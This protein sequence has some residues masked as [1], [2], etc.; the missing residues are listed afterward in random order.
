MYVIRVL[1]LPCVCYKGPF[2]TLHICEK[3]SFLALHMIRVLSL[4]CTCDIRA[5]FLSCTSYMI[6]YNWPEARLITYLCLVAVFLLDDD[7]VPVTV[8]DTQVNK[9]LLP[10]LYTSFLFLYFNIIFWF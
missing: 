5:L 2:P 1:F 4:S 3:L 10:D 7:V 6:R 8:C 9:L